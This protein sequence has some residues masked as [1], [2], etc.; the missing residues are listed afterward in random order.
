MNNESMTAKPEL[1]HAARFTRMYPQIYGCVSMCMGVS[2]FSRKTQCVTQDKHVFVK[3]AV[4]K[5][6]SASQ[7][8]NL[9]KLKKKKNRERMMIP[10]GILNMLW[11]SSSQQ[12]DSVFQWSPTCHRTVITPTILVHECFRQKGKN[13][14]IFHFYLIFSSDFVKL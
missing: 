7:N 8:H 14:V 2:V 11:A 4:H 12:Y 3:A 10:V 1:K 9:G 13:D 6:Q 5:T